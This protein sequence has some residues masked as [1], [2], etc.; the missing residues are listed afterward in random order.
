M[1]CSEYVTL[2]SAEDIE[3]GRARGILDAPGKAAAAASGNDGAPDQAPDEDADGHMG[4]PE[5]DQLA[6]SGNKHLTCPAFWR[7]GKFAPSSILFWAEICSQSQ[8]GAGGA[9]GWAG[10]G[11]EQEGSLL[12]MVQEH[13]PV[14]LGY[15]SLPAMMMRAS[16]EPDQAFGPNMPP[17]ALAIAVR[18]SGLAKGTPRLDSITPKSIF[19]W[20]P[21]S[22]TASPTTPYCLASMRHLELGMPPLHCTTLLVC[23]HQ[24]ADASS[25]KVGVKPSSQALLAASPAS[26]L[27]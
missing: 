16:P 26:Y 23:G 9:A 21:H 12:P 20:Q 10:H 13:A 15:H 2:L 18:A 3:E 24:S 5:Q 8:S 4:P 14:L 27:Q 7:L 11:A 1:L 19:E 17:E 25:C 6:T 22:G